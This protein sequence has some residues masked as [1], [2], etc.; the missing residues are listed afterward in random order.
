MCQLQL[1][2]LASN[3]KSEFCLVLMC[4]SIQALMPTL[5]SLPSQF[6][7]APTPVRVL[8]RRVSIDMQSV[9]LHMHEKVS[10]NP[11]FILLHFKEPQRITRRTQERIQ[12]HPINGMDPTSFDFNL[13]GVTEDFLFTAVC[14]KS[15]DK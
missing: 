7:P 12:E 14:M 15:I 4:T 1:N 8:I 2:A 6:H 3:A 13:R 9:C 5:H 10:F 11:R